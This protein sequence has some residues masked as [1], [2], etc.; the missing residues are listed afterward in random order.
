MQR[1]NRRW[2]L[3]GW[4]SGQRP[5]ESLREPPKPKGL[6][7]GRLVLVSP[8]YPEASFNAG[9][10]M[11]RNK[12]IYALANQALVIDSALESGGTWDGAVEALKKQ[13][14]PVY[15]R[16]PGEGAGNAALIEKG[17]TVF[18]SARAGEA[19][20]DIFANHAS[21]GLSEVSPSEPPQPSLLDLVADTAKVAEVITESGPTENNDVPQDVG[22][23]V[24]HA[25]EP[26]P[27]SVAQHLLKR[28]PGMRSLWICSKSL[29]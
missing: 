16:S 8:F 4:H 27:A 24:V 13:W 18:V 11:G 12:Y 23:T 28:Q 29:S 6:A 17:D 25:A 19:L 10:A 20:S 1:S 5:I 26:I 15:V 22:V 7:R 14:C 2:R 9:N 21:Q 3:L